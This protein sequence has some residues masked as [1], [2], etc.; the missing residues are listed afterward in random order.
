MMNSLTCDEGLDELGLVL[1]VV[2]Q[3]PLKVL[4]LP[5]NGH[6]TDQL[7][8]YVPVLSCSLSGCKQKLCQ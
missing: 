6:L 7:R 2:L 3:H 8:F 4:L 5:L 1:L